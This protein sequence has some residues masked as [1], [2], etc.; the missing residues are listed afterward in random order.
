[1]SVV[2]E[3][4]RAVFVLGL[5]GVLSGYASATN[6]LDHPRSKDELNQSRIEARH[7]AGMQD[8]ADLHRARHV[9]GKEVKSSEDGRTLGRIHDIVLTPDLNSVSYVALSRGGAFGLNRDLYAIPWSAF[10]SGFGNTHY[11]PI[12]ESHLEAMNGFK[13][14]YWPTSSS[15][16]WAAAPGSASA[17]ASR[18]TARE[19]SRDVQ[20]RRVS[21]IIGRNVKDAQGKQTGSIRDMII[22]RDTGQIRYTIVSCGGVLGIGSRYAAVPPGAIDLQPRGLARLNVGRDKLAAGSFSPMRWPDL[23]SSAFGQ[24]VAALYGTQPGRA[25]LGYVPPESNVMV[26]PQTNVQTP[27]RPEASMPERE[28]Q[29]PDTRA[30][31]PGA[32]SFNPSELKT[33][34]G[35]VVHASW[36][37]A[38]AA[39]SG[40]AALRLKTA[41]GKIVRVNLGPRDYISEQGVSLA[42]GDH[43]AVT[44]ADVRIG[45]RNRFVA[46]EVAKDGQVLKLRDPNG[47]PLWP[48]STSS[49]KNKESSAAIPPD[50]DRQN[51]LLDW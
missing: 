29:V 51:P 6:C 9:I 4:S 25:A 18:G 43:V 12:T 27:A 45:W 40:M 23:S 50:Y 32:V 1:M 42:A 48:E 41:D 14:A 46:T 5:V 20:A 15:S 17:P 22:T 26:V 31:S 49:D 33:I 24:S 35:T 47:H 39:G 8:S 13:E 2:H 21:Q 19:Q 28:R 37:G 36:L 7:D 34:E 10:R 3:S 16:G 30:P 44:G 38:S 11:L